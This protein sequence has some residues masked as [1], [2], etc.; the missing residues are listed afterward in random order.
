MFICI[1]LL[2]AGHRLGSTRGSG[3]GNQG[4]GNAGGGGGKSWWKLN[5][6]QSKRAQQAWWFNNFGPGK[7]REFHQ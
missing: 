5:E 1:I 2:A 6:E 7:K 4:G 3:V